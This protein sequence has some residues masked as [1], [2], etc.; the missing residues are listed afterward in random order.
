MFQLYGDL[1]DIKDYEKEVIEQTDMKE[2]SMVVYLCN[3]AYYG[4]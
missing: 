1:T 2:K 3:P 4:Y